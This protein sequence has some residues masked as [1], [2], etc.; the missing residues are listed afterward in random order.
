MQTAPI[1]NLL[2]DRFIGAD[3]LRRQL[4]DILNTLPKETKVVITQHGEPKAV[5]LDLNTYLELIDIQEDVVQ[6]GYLDSL[7]KELGEVRRGKGIPHK[8]LVAK[9]KL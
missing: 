6:P 1:S 7:Y 3:D 4:S 2:K 9:L 8:A 5:L